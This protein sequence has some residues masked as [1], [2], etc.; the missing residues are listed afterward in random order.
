MA[1]YEIS[2]EQF[3]RID[4]TSFSDAGL[5]ER[6]D[7]QRLLRSQIEIV[8]P[9]TL[10]IS[11]E[12]SQWEDSSRRIDLLGIDKDANLVVIELKRTEDGGH[13][14]LQSIRYA[15]MIS[16]MTFDKAVEVYAE[17]LARIGCT[18]V[19]HTSL[20]EFLNCGDSGP[21]HFA[22]DVRIVLVSAEFS[23]EL[24]TTVL[25]LNDREMDIQCIRIKPYNDNG[26][27]LVDVQQI[28]PLPETEAYRVQIKEK[29]QRE[30]IARKTSRENTKYD[31]TVNG[32][33][34]E[35]LSKRVAIFMAVRALAD[36]GH[37][38]DAISAAV[39]WRQSMFR[40]ADGNLSVDQFVADQQAVAANDGR[41]FDDSRYFC[42]DGELIHFNGKTYAFS[43][44]WGPHTVRAIDNLIAA[45]P[46][47]KIE[48]R[49]LE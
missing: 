22:Q 16:A 3:R 5:R 12:F 14:E 7:L 18:A 25:W 49:A 15:A 2:S 35:R 47:V 9:K 40:V 4:E 42:A 32:H 46:D 39:P 34:H 24:T 19:A 8:S 26:R 21:D 30:R 20:L 48:C 23:K 33:V 11:E 10:I 29:E 37:S 1:I 27:I 41:G 43:N 38:P 44:Q 28:I 31:V 45:F 17:Y 13:M 36:S 6:Q